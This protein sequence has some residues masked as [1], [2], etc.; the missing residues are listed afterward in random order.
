MCKP[1]EC[2][3]GKKSARDT[4][5]VPKKKWKMLVAAALIA[6]QPSILSPLA[7]ESLTRDLVASFLMPS[8]EAVTDKQKMADD[9]LR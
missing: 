6:L 3:T 8:A 4:N 1:L 9:E 2:I 7:A 5:G